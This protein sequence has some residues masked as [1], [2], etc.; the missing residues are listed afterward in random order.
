MHVRDILQH[1]IG[2]GRM[3]A[4]SYLDDLDDAALMMRPHPGC[5]HLNWQVGHLITSEHQIVESVV[6]GSM[7]PLPA[8]FAE[9]Y[10]KETAV[11]DDPAAF[12]SKAELMRV[13]EEQRAGTL[14]ALAALPDADFDRPTPEPM[15]AYAPT[16][17][18]A[19]ELQASHWM[20]HAGQWVIVRRALGKPA[21]F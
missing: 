14:A 3:V 17:A 8:G 13:F 9:R 11:N 18:A 21:I 5:N 6:P 12:D 20:M 10:A 4:M 15:Q 2:L 19:F 7:P 16:V 1:S